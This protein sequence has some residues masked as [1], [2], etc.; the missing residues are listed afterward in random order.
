[1]PQDRDCEARERESR[2]A[3]LIGN[4]KILGYLE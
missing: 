2:E 1:M 3:G 4:K